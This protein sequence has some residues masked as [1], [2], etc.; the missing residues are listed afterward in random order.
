MAMKTHRLWMNAIFVGALLL[1][2]RPLPAQTWVRYEAEAGSKVKIEGTSTV[3]DWTAESLVIGGSMEVDASFDADPKTVK[4]K[5]KVEVSI[6]VRMLK[7]SGGK[8]MNEVM[9]EAMNMKDHPKIEYRL[10]E[11]VPKGPPASP[12]GPY[13]FDTKGVLTIS[14]VSKTNAMPVTLERIDK[15]K[16]KITGTTPLKMTDFG[17]KPPSP[18]IALGLIKTG[19]EIKITFEWLTAQRTEAAK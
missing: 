15:T 13:E 4:V 1:L 3:H 6:P 11:M 9:Q 18:T 14:G 19:D 16:M 5:P 10:L 2:A 17:I 7:T 8:R 12:A